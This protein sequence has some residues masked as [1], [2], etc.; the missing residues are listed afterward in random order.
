CLLARV[1]LER[2]DG[3]AAAQVLGAVTRGDAEPEEL[4]QVRAAVAAHTPGP[5]RLVRHWEEP[6]GTPKVLHLSPDGRQVL[7]G[8]RDQTVQIWEL[9]EGR[10]LQVFRGHTGSVT[11]VAWGHDGRHA[12]SAGRDNTLRC[13]D[14]A[15]GECLRTLADPRAETGTAC[16]SPD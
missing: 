6:P 1:H 4:R 15:T 8:C 7:A 13:W 11:W 5:R 10:C 12:W 2:G 9:P 16:L 14:A 3:E